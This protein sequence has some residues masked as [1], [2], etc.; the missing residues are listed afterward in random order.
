MVKKK[1]KRPTELERTA[2]HEAGHQVVTYRLGFYTHTT[3]IRP[4]PGVAGSA[5]GEG[6]WADGSRDADYI[7][8]LYA[9]FAAE[10]R[11][12]PE[13]ADS[14]GSCGDDEEAK[15]LLQYSDLGEP[16]CRQ[17]ANDLVAEYWPEIEAVAAQLLED[18][19][20]TG[21]EQEMICDAIAEALDW[22]VVLSEYRQRMAYF[23][24][25]D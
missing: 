5:Q 21:E 10:S 17:R 12:D 23:Q 6:Y 25:E 8:T 16:E 15:E 1:R 4:V 11:H 19:T 14:C 20:L 18:E 24:R 13:A 2:Y 9:G 7:V 22:R 3:T